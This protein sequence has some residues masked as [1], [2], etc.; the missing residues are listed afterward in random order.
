VRASGDGVAGRF[1]AAGRT[2]LVDLRPAGARL[3]GIVHCQG[4][5]FPIVLERAERATTAP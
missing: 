4:R 2:W 5:D 1:E 3:V